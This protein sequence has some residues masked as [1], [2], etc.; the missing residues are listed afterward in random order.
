[1]DLLQKQAD[2]LLAQLTSL[3]N[4][5]LDEKNLQQQIVSTVDSLHGLNKELKNVCTQTALCSLSLLIFDR[6]LQ[7]VEHNIALKQM[8]RQVTNASGSEDDDPDLQAMKLQ[9][10][11]T[12]MFRDRIVILMVLYYANH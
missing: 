11:G 1:M 9:L 3:E 6:L 7:L 5:E 12:S 4:L 8:L 10:E 2:E